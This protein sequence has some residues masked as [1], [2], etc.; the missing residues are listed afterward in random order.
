M[1]YFEDHGLPLVQLREQRRELVVALIGLKDPISNVQI[2]EIA[3]LQ[4]AIAAMEAVVGD[5]DSQIEFSPAR[6][7]SASAFSI[8]RGSIVGNMGLVF[9]RR[10]VAAP[11]P[12]RLAR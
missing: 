12:L 4:Q 2:A 6:R 9:G 1:N 5:L 8:A 11:V 10:G 3:S 7:Q